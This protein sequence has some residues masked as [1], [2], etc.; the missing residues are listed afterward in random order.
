MK[1]PATIHNKNM[2]SS[3]Y[4]IEKAKNITKAFQRS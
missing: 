1:S 2:E 4:L 3:M